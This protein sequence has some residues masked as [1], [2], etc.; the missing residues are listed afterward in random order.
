MTTDQSDAWAVFDIEGA[1][2]PLLEKLVNLD[3]ATFGPGSATR[4]GLDHMG[5]FVIRRD[6][7]RVAVMAMRSAAEYVWHI[8]ETAARRQ[9]VGCPP[10]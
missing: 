5:V 10:A 6:H 4:T 7:H 3:L 1:I 9:N 2:E 8:L